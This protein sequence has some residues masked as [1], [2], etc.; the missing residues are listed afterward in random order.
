VWV[1][2][3]LDGDITV[4]N[5]ATNTVAGTID[6]ATGAAPPP[7]STATLDGAPLGITFVNA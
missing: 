1:G 3:I 6:G 7:A 5:P 4:I 2:N